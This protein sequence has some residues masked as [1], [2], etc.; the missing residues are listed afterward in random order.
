MDASPLGFEPGVTPFAD[1]AAV[2]AITQRIQ[3][4][5]AA[6]LSTGASIIS[7]A[8]YERI[9]TDMVDMECFAVLRAAQ[10]FGVPTIGLRGISDGRS[11]LARLEDW[12]HSL[13][14]IDQGLAAALDLFESQVRDRRFAL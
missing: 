10:R 5:P 11:E 7:G 14:R 13:A 3:G 2:I 12:T 9:A 1:H 6:S 8:G 4:I